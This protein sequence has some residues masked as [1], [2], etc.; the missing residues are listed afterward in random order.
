MI[1]FFCPTCRAKVQAPEDKVGLPALCPKCHRLF[2]VPRT[3]TPGLDTPVSTPTSSTQTSTPVPEAPAQHELV[4]A[5]LTAAP[6]RSVRTPTTTAAPA[7]AA[8]VKSRKT[9]LLVIAVAGAPIIGAAIVFAMF[10][11]KPPQRNIAKPRASATAGQTSPASDP[12]QTFKPKALS[13]VQPSQLRPATT[14][15]RPTP[16]KKSPF[17]PGVI[18]P[19]LEPQQ[20]SF[21]P[22]PQINSGVAR[23]AMPLSQ[24]VTSPWA[25][26]PVLIDNTVYI[27]V[28]NGHVWGFDARTTKTVFQKKLRFTVRRLTRNGSNLMAELNERQPMPVVEFDHSID[29]VDPENVEDGRSILQ[30]AAY[31]WKYHPSLDHQVVLFKGNY[32]L[33]EFE[34]VKVLEDGKEAEYTSKVFGMMR[35]KI[36]LLPSGPLGYDNDAV[37]E[38]DEHLLPTRRMINLNGNSL[39]MGSAVVESW[40]A[41]DGKTLCYVSVTQKNARMMIWS[42]DGQRKIRECVVTLHPRNS[43]EAKSMKP[44]GKRLWPLGDGYLFCGGELTW[45]PAGQGEIVQFN[46]QQWRPPEV[47]PPNLTAPVI[48]GDKVFVG[49][50]GG[51]IYIFDTAAF[52]TAAGPSRSAAAAP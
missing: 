3:S 40:L 4:E 19:D 10:A 25:T 27:A 49:F 1:R 11:N 39:D 12:S 5:P 2:N 33:P 34:K 48:A 35:W 47:T 51:G 42:L 50:E 29:P 15:A 21:D 16:T 13:S 30:S 23:A 14:T 18:R 7:S 8:P 17:S 43:F 26:A 22:P 6:M 31:P 45:M 9:N 20:P 37:F 44:S 41:G 24:L 46:P 38:L 32:Y 28:R 36:A 52:S